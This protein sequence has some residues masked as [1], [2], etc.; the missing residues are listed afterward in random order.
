MIDLR[1]GDCL[2]IMKDIPNNSIDLVVIDP[3]YLIENTKAGGNSK[4]AKSI[5]GMNNE[6]KENNLTNGFDIKCLD[7]LFR[8]MKKPNIYIWCNHKQI[9]MYL[10]Y[11][12]KEKD[13]SFD[14]IIWNKTNAMPLFNNKY[15]TDKEYCL[16]FRKGGYCNPNSYI[17]AKTVYYQPI[18]IKDKRLYNHPTIKPL[19]II[20]TI[21]KNS[22]KEN[23]TILDCFMG[24]GTT[25]VACKKL[26]RNF[27]GIELD[28]EYY[29]IA[30]K[31][32]EEDQQ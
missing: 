13:C 8:V 28:K 21:I 23:D 30:K 19:N 22:S 1:Q 4:L 14:I 16:Y 29:E 9:P 5:Q 20:E 17:D 15:L 31:R 10:D 11:F 3:P 12:V 24:S 18:N 7:E 32:M 26:N 27:I 25:G 6:I 2:E